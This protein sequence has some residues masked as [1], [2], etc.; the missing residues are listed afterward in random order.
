LKRTKERRD[1]PDD[2]PAGDYYVMGSPGSIFWI[3]PETAGR[4]SRML[5][6]IWPRRWLR[7]TDRN[8]SRA[9]VR[10]ALVEY[11]E[12][13]SELQRERS[14]AFQRALRRERRSDRWTDED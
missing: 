10:S 12:E 7:F 2:E 6:S 13:C 4:V 3:G 8:G 9:W 5:Q 14:R 1:D 11:I